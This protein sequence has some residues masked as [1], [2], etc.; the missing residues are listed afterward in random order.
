MATHHYPEPDADLKGLLNSPRLIASAKAAED[1]LR[2]RPKLR[3][4]KVQ[5]KPP[6]MPNTAWYIGYRHQETPTLLHFV[7]VPSTVNVEFMYPQFLPPEV[8]DRL[9]WQNTSWKYARLNL[10]GRDGILAI[11]DSYLSAVDGPYKAG[12]LKQGGRSA[13][14]AVLKRYLQELLPGRTV[15]NN[16]RPDALRSAKN[17]PL[18]LDLYVPDLKLAVEVQGPQHFRRLHG[19]NEALLANDQHKKA[20]CR[21]AGIRFMWFEWHGLTKSLFRLPAADQLSH[22]KGLIEKLLGGKHTFVWW[23]NVDRQHYE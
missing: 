21:A 10:H 11:I 18:E 4:W 17:V 1:L 8:F 6:H 19:P 9:P 12:K 13:A 23:E 15:L 14:E 22:L 7:L 2:A 3:V 16:H 5:C 20:W